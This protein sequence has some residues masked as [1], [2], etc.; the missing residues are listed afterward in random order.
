MRCIASTGIPGQTDQI[1]FV[2]DITDFDV[3]L[4]EMG[5]PGL[6]TKIML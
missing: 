3:H 6:E 1:A 4:L 5:I 2:H